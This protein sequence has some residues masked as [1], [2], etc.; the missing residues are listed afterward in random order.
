MA[1]VIDVAKYFI[2]L[3]QESSKY[4]ITPLKLQKLIYYAQGFYLKGNKDPLFNDDLLAWDHGPVN[5][6]VYDEY[7]KYKYHPIPKES[8]DY[9]GKLT[10]KEKIAIDEAWREFGDLG[11]KALEELTHQEDPWLFT[12]KD[13]V[14]KIEMIRVYFKEQYDYIGT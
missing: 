8:F 14:I 5:R 12:A 13:K 9:N 1:N 11:G 3:S 10:E 2:S 6:E 4:A 7:K